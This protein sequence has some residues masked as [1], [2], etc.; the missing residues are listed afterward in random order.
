MLGIHPK[1]P[2]FQVTISGGEMDRLVD[3]WRKPRYSEQRLNTEEACQSD[4]G[5][6]PDVLFALLRL[7]WLSRPPHERYGV[8]SKT[9]NR[10]GG[11]VPTA[12]GSG[13][14]TSA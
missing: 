5:P 14:K 6:Y 9:V 3:S 7:R 11:T 8:I 13:P 10:S 12:N 4:G 2:R 1:I